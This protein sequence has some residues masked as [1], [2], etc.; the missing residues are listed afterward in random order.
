M[1]KD[2]RALKKSLLI[3]FMFSLCLVLG[4]NTWAFA[5]TASRTSAQVPP[6]VLFIS[7][8]SESY[9]IVPEQ[10][11]GLHEALDP[12]NILLDIEYMDTK[13]FDT[14]ENIRNFYVSIKYKLEHMAQPYQAIVVGDDRALDFALEYQEELFPKL[15]IV[16][17][18]I[19]DIKRAEEAADNPYITGIAEK[20]P[21]EENVDF[22]LELQPQ[23]KYI[24]GIVDNSITG[25]G[26][27]EQFNKVRSIYPELDF[28]LLDSSQYTYDEMAD[29]LQ[30]L[31]QDSIV[32]FLS[33]NY[34]K[35]GTYKSISE[36][37]AFIAFNTSVPVYRPTIGGVGYG[38]LGGIQIDYVELGKKAGEIV[39][40]VLQGTPISSILMLE[41]S[42]IYFI[43]DYKVIKQFKLNEKLFPQDAVMINKELSYFEEN[44]TLLSIVFLVLLVLVVISILLG[45]DSLK[46]RSMQRDLAAKNQELSATYEQLAAT[47]EEL[48]YQY[49][50]VKENVKHLDELKQRYD[51]A[52]LSTNSV[53]WELNLTNRNI[54]FSENFKEWFTG[55]FQPIQNIDTF[56]QKYVDGR[57]LLRLNE[58]IASYLNN[59]KNEINIEFP[60]TTFTNKVRW[61]KA[62]GKSTETD[63]GEIILYGILTDVTEIKL[64]Q[65]Y[66]DHLAHYDYL[67]DLPNRRSFIK[68]LKEEI[69]KG[70]SLYI[71]LMDIDNFKEINDTLGHVWGDKLLK[72]VAN[73]LAAFAGSNMYVSRFGGDEFL[74]MFTNIDGHSIEC[75]LRELCAIFMEPIV[76]EQYEFLLKFSLGLTRFPEDGTDVD[77]LIRNADTALYQVK[78]NGKNHYLF[79][80]KEML[81]RLRDKAEIEGILQKALH[82]DG[83]YLLYQPQIDAQ[84]GEVISFEALVR[85]KNH[86]IPPNVF[87]KIAE[88]SDLI[89]QIGR[90]VT[91]EAI[92]QAAA[93]KDMGLPRKPISINF[94]SKQIRDKE[95]LNFL[96]DTLKEFNLEPEY[97]EIEITESVLVEETNITLELLKQIKDLGIKIALDDFGTGF[98]SI[99]YLTFIPVDKV[100]LDKSLCDKFLSPDNIKVMESII[101][102]VQSLNLDITAE[103]VE[104]EWQYEQLRE[105]GCNSIQGYYFS[106]PLPAAEAERIYNKNFLQMDRMDCKA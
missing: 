22:A 12:Q 61:I 39:V 66:I 23:V 4:V 91:K 80:S 15:P 69:A 82:E 18:G 50:I 86:Q 73:K 35:S 92:R 97:I 103:G 70:K 48:R 2:F 105:S 45:M 26:D 16:F 1:K 93:W 27:K 99:N 17:L 29:L 75:Y 57:T 25:I 74:L 10:I 90:V 9:D 98:S 41:E 55:P 19:N 20:I 28:E 37:A 62:H 77:Q 43:F 71:A 52:L 100:K 33:M 7:S 89:W 72:A 11:V 94:S 24:Y 40:Q 32:L 59:E 95:Y 68:K 96:K 5:Q 3:I 85:L 63:M 104:E 44:K 14:E 42:P 106:K 49:K 65:E 13:R 30:D 101:S 53:V 38:V 79:Y 56:L 67:T 102:L 34:D 88:E 83:F 46:H 21:I 36:A 87:I 8:Y 58:E 84:S 54:Y 6:R 76:L 60:I 81:Q 64:Q 51:Q 47:E 31:P 78:K